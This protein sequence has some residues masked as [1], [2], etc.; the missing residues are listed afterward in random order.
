MRLQYM[1][2][3]EIQRAGWVTVCATR[4]L[5]SS[6]RW[7]LGCGILDLIKYEDEALKHRPVDIEVMT[8]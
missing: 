4:S 7:Q 5:S 8:K 1:G 2:L 3:S 6:G